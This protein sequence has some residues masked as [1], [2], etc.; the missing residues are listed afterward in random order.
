MVMRDI[1]TVVKGEFKEGDQA[2][3][4]IQDFQ[5][6]LDVSCSFSGMCCVV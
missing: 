1:S 3:N 4:K 5:V 6:Q 2:I